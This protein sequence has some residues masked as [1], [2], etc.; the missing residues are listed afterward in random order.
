[1]EARL[2]LA[3]HSSPRPR[4]NL[5]PSSRGDLVRVAKRQVSAARPARTNQ[6]KDTAGTGQLLR[7]SRPGN[8]T[9]TILT[10]QS[11]H[12]SA[13]PA[14]LATWVQG[15]WRIENQ[16]HWV[17][18][19]TY[20]KDRSQ[21]RTGHAPTVMATLRNA[22]ISILRLAGWTNIAAALRHHARDAARPVNLLLT[23]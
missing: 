2:S 12:Q 20:D 5:A 3:R 1:M 11:R 18:D 6:R 17:R 13:S 15:H 4:R 22:A 9:E 19:V 21:I 7:E 8:T 14:V 10:S 23:S 16:L